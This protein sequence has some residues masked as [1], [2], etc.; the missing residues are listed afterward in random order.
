[1]YKQEEC[2]NDAQKT[3]SIR[4]ICTPVLQNMSL[5]SPLIDSTLSM[6][7]QFYQREC[8]KVK[9]FYKEEEC[10]KNDHSVEATVF[11]RRDF[12][13]LHERYA[14]KK[15]THAWKFRF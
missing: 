14:R 5:P 8:S 11:L 3:L 7:N 6:M 15:Q 12:T 2:C 4:E 10:C 9:T 13:F 1:M